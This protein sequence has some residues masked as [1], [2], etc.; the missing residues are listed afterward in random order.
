MALNDVE[1]W[2]TTAASNTDVG[3]INLAE[4]M[5]RKLVNNAVREMMAEIKRAVANQGSDIASAATCNIAATGTSKYAKVTGT[6]GITSFGSAPAGTTRWIEFTGA[7]TITHDAT[8]LILPGAANYTTAAGDMVFGVCEGDG[9][10]GIGARWR[11]RIFP[12]S[13]AAVVP[14]TNGKHKLWIPAAAMLA[15]PVNGPAF[16]QTVGSDV[17]YATLDYDAT[18][19]EI[20]QF[21]ISMPSSW[22]EGTVTFRAVWTAASGSG[23][24]VWKVFALARSD[25]DVISGGVGTGQTS[26]DTLLTA[27]DLHRSPE[28]SAITVSDTPVTNDTIFFLALR[29]PADA[30]DTLAVDA[31]LIGIELYFTTNEAVD[32]AT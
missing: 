3:T 13:G 1:L 24:V 28:S 29:T 30:S 21:C 25:D 5:Q 4:G 20:A 10:L 18:T 9:A 16:A 14:N 26:T 32:V 7:L 17:V 31:R 2:S 19:S 15:N 6:T 23:G 12:A 11:A 27:G 8:N 22:D